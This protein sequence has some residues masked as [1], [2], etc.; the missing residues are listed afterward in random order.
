MAEVTLAILGLERLGTSFGL[1][2]KRYMGN[3]DARHAFTILGFDQRGYNGKKA[4]QLGAVDNFVRGELD[5][6]QNAHVV[7]LTMP[8]YQV[9][10]VYEIIGPNLKPGTVILDTSPLKTPSIEWARANLPHEPEIAAYMV[11][12]TPILNPDVLIDPNLEVDGAR[13]DLFDKGTMI[14]AP[15]PDC[16][17]EAVQLASELA[18]IL[19]TAVHFMDPA[20]HDG[21]IAAMEGLPAILG[22]SLFRTISGA[23]AWDDL[24]RMANPSFGLATHHLRFQHPD[25]LWSLL[26]YNR[27]NVAR[28]LGQLIETLDALRDS[29]LNDEEGLALEAVLVDGATKYEEWEG[30][31]LANRWEAQPDE[32]VPSEGFMSTM[33]GM[34]FGRHPRR[35]DDNAARKD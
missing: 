6:V 8:Y 34:L 26:Q 10:D 22:A 20:E 19:G 28:Y 7:V 25:S 4:K 2:L 32:A 18:Y 30:H 9:K 35:K 31:R 14:L 24:R 1:A 3:K 15:A 17:P 12:V 23:D 29:L 5:A 33:G 21:L 13:A 27:E 11:G 16:P